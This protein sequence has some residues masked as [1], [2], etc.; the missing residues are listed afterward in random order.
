MEKA[1]QDIVEAANIAAP[2]IVA[3]VEDDM[4][5]ADTY[6]ERNAIQPVP[7]KITQ[8]FHPHPGTDTSHTFASLTKGID[9]MDVNGAHELEGLSSVVYSYNLF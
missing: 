8:V 9:T 6:D 2:L 5:E 3:G 7:A 1:A 4:A